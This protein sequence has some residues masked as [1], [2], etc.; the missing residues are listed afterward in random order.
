[1]KQHLPAIV[2]CKSVR[3]S[4]GT[5]KALLDCKPRIFNPG[6]K[7]YDPA[8]QEYADVSNTEVQFKRAPKDGNKF[9][10]HINGKNTF[11]WFKDLWQSLRQTISRGIHR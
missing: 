8:R 5:I 7:L 10:L 9:R 3:M 4:E 2:D 11:Q 6:K 1:M